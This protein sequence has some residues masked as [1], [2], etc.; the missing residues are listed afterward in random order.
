MT[1]LDFWPAVVGAVIIAAVGF[2]RRDR[3]QVIAMTTG[4]YLMVM[5]ALLWSWSLG[6]EATTAIFLAA[7]GA[8]LTTMGTERSRHAKRQ[9]ADPSDERLS[10]T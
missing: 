1:A 6:R 5:L 7:V 10:R 2:L 3:L 4:G 8:T 9:Q